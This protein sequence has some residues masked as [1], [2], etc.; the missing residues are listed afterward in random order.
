[1][2]ELQQKID[3]GHRRKRTAGRICHAWK[4]DGRGRM[5]QAGACRG[6][7]G[8][9][10][11]QWRSALF[12][13]HAIVVPGA[14]QTAVALVHLEASMFAQVKIEL[15]PSS[16][17]IRVDPAFELLSNEAR[18]F[19]EELRWE[20]ESGPPLQVGFRRREHVVRPA[21]TRGDRSHTILFTERSSFGETNL[22]KSSAP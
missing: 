5:P 18:Q 4:Q 22:G 14:L 2:L 19:A 3:R 9:P 6:A 17:A 13:E 20:N 1:R 8:E 15:H 7:A 21:I 11:R 10:N 12:F 16:A